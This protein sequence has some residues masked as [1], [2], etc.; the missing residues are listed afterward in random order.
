MAD[1]LDNIDIHVDCAQCDVAYHIPASTVAESQRLIEEGC[2]G[3]EYECPASLFA[4][5]VDPADL[6]ALAGAWR[7]VERS[8]RG[9]AQGLLLTARPAVSDR[10]VVQRDPAL[11]RWEDDGGA[12]HRSREDTPTQLPMTVTVG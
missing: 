9:R 2:P 12:M 11:A 1:I 8:V 6:R 10:A 3:S 5:L 7:R 4:T